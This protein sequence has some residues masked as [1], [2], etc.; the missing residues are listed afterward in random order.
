MRRV[1]ARDAPGHGEQPGREGH[2]PVV[3]VELRE[4]TAQD[5]AR[6]RLCRR[7][8]ARA[9][10]DE[11]PDRG[12]AVGEHLLEGVAIARGGALGEIGVGRNPHDGASASFR[13][14]GQG[15]PWTDSGHS[16][17]TRSRGRPGDAE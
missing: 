14:I 16:V 12:Q 13:T 15:F 3:V 9:P 6:E 11:G 1:R 7:A 4:G 8:P 17:S 2:L 5:P 10:A